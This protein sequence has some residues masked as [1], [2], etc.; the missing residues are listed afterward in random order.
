[1]TRMMI[2]Y[3]F[4]WSDDK[5]WSW[6]HEYFFCMT[7]DTQKRRIHHQNVYEKWYECVWK[8]IWMCESYWSSECVWRVMWMCESYSSSECVWSGIWMCQSYSSSECVSRVDHQNV[9]EEWYKCVSRIWSLECV[10]RI[11]HPNVHEK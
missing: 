2:W 8:V 10:S 6:W 11:D 3:T 1:M 9:Y 5:E 4:W 7:L